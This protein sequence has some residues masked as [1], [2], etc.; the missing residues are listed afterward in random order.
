MNSQN[1]GN[2]K[3]KLE[4]GGRVAC[5]R[6]PPQGTLVPAQ[7][8]AGPTVQLVSFRPDVRLTDWCGEWRP[9]ESDDVER[10]PFTFVKVT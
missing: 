1:C 4:D 9:R 8:I 10:M 6:N 3:Y 5:A 2:C 7:G